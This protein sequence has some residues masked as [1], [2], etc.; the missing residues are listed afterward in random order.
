MRLKGLGRFKGFK[1]LKG[2]KGLNLNL[3][4]SFNLK[5]LIQSLFQGVQKEIII[6]PCV[7]RRFGIY[8]L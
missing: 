1:G 3:F 6:I 4:N 7:L 8:S 5:R 2:L